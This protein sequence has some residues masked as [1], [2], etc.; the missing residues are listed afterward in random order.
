MTKKFSVLQRAA[1]LLAALCLL[2]GLALP[3]CAE[4]T[5]DALSAQN[6]ETMQQGNDPTAE[7]LPGE[8][9]DEDKTAPD[10]AAATTPTPT[11]T[12]TPAATTTPTPTATPAATPTPAPTATL[13]ATPTPTPTAAPTA[14]PTT[15]P[16][17]TPTAKPTP[18]VTPIPDDEEN[19]ESKEKFV[20]FAAVNAVAE[21][22]TANPKG[23][24]TIYFVPPTNWT[25]AG[26]VEIY[27]R[28]LR[29]A[30]NN[31]EYKAAMTKSGEITKIG[32]R[33]IYEIELSYADS[34][35]SCPH[36]GY[37]WVQFQVGDNDNPSKRIRIRT[38]DQDSNSWLFVGEMGGKCF[39]GDKYFEGDKD[40]ESIVITDAAAVSK[41][42]AYD[43]IVKKH[44]RYG[45]QEIY[46]QNK[47]GNELTN[48]TVTFYEKVNGEYK[49]VGKEQTISSV[50]AGGVSDAITIPGEPCAYVSFTD[51][52]GF[53]G[54]QYYNFYKDDVASNEVGTFQ[55]NAKTNDC[56]IYNGQSDVQWGAPNATR[57]YFDATFSDMSY[58]G[59]S[60][61]KTAD[62]MPGNDGKLYYILT[63]EGKTKQ[64]GEMTRLED[65]S[66]SR[67][68]WYVNAPEGYTKV[69]FSDTATLPTSNDING[70]ATATLTWGDLKEPCFYAD[71]GDDITYGG[72]YR[73]GY[74]GEKSAIRDVEKGKKVKGKDAEIVKLGTGTFTPQNNVKYI[75]STLYDYYSDYELNG[76]TRANYSTEEV[77]T[78]RSYVEFEQFDRA[79]SDYYKDYEA[80]TTTGEKVQYPLYTGHFQPD[81]MDKDW[82][83]K[84]AANL[85]LYGWGYEN[86]KKDSLYGRFMAVNNANVDV[87]VNTNNNYTVN[88]HTTFQGL[89]S[90]TR[91][92]NHN[93]TLY[94][95]DLPEPHF[96]EA[97]LT[98]ENSAKAVLGKVYKDVAFPFKQAPIFAESGDR[99]D[100]ENAA[101]Y[102][103][104]D[105]SETPLYLKQDT[106]KGG[107][108]YLDSKMEGDEEKRSRNL[109]TINNPTGG[110]GFFPFNQYAGNHVNQ[111]NYGYGA[112]LQFDFTLTE[113]G[114]VVV[115]KD[116]KG[117][118]KVPI[119]FFFSG[120][121]D[122]WVFI[123]DQ[124]VL[125][126]GGAHAKAQGLLEFGKDA[127]GDNTVTSYV[128]NI[129]ASNN[130]NYTQLDRSKNVTFNGT[131]YQFNWKSNENK[132]MTLP[133]N[134]KHTLTMYYMERGMWESNMA[135]AFNFPD[136]NELQVEKQVD[137]DGVRE[138]LQPYFTNSTRQFT[139][140]IKN[141]A[142]HYAALNPTATTDAGGSSGIGFTTK[143]YTIPDYDS[144]NKGKLVDA[145]GAQYTTSKDE[146]IHTVEDNGTFDLQNG[147]I[148]TF[149]DQF[150]RGSYISLQEDLQEDA[151]KKLYAPTWEIHENG[152]LVMQS[153]GGTT[154]ELPDGTPQKIMQG[155]G[156]T[157]DDGRKE[158][159]QEGEEDGRKIQNTGYTVTQKPKENSIVFR[160][161]RDPDGT[162]Q[163]TKLKVKFIN[164]VKTGSLSIT[165]QVPQ[166]EYEKLKGETYTFTVEYS[167]IGGMQ[168]EGGKKVTE[169]VQVKVGDPPFTL[170]GIPIGTTV[171]V[172][173]G[174][175]P[176][177][178][179]KSI[180]VNGS[181]Q[182]ADGKASGT[183][184]ADTTD[185]NDSGKTIPG[186]RVVFTNTARKPITIDVKKTWQNAK[187][188]LPESI[189]IELQRRHAGSADDAPWTD[190]K[191]TEVALTKDETGKWTHTF[192]G[193][194]AYDISD[195]KNTYYEYRVVEWDAEKGQ[196][197]ASGTLTLGNYN[198]KVDSETKTIKD[199]VDSVSLTLTNTQVPPVYELAITKQGLDE[200]GNK[201]KLLNGV[202]FKLEKLNGKDVDTTFNGNKGSMPGTT[203]GDGNDAGKCRFTNLSEGSYR[204]TELKTV[205]GY[206]LLAAPIEFTLQKGECLINGTKQENMV[207]GKPASGYTVSLTINNRKGFTLPHTGADAPSLWLL[208]GLPLLVAGLLVLVFRY[209]RKGGKRS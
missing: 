166:D 119:R 90:N 177:R 128:S 37:V 82:F 83:S 202:E 103:Y 66:E 209:N 161:Y 150:R 51:E 28:G 77:Q 121:D 22:G 176:N 188:E 144:V 142:T 148:V 46:F 138:K 203:T 72:G 140:G 21:G 33:P 165:K 48:I 113:D 25:K 123:D 170:K 99:N 52:N 93:P 175:T 196:Y 149:A 171:T 64:T 152:K 75:D 137:A 132:Q 85:D 159:Y 182:L 15:T 201:P 31:G 45:G 74:W 204:L 194:D 184:V 81:K 6:V 19:G 130:N 147:E 155:D 97:F 133:K 65:R 91:D 189:R 145:A 141:W 1:A 154:V 88:S 186:V 36:G 70:R 122:V 32:E 18:T 44:V 126:V 76:K 92:G 60:E 185:A 29:G 115:G 205:D 101:Q 79:L 12:A 118:K 120:D 105:S 135:V 167:N 47:T 80:S 197:T 67:H 20:T 199:N 116:E 124:L 127:S 179:I 43:D 87:N 100:P 172:T 181:E 146:K 180:T 40:K 191:G 3:V 108:Y 198:Y 195:N 206:N 125:D 174:S 143:Q 94:G 2:A 61:S 5:D 41:L 35:P 178:Y 164:K 104:Y 34:S 151:D 62:G 10:G 9:T 84:I 78:H 56:F 95:T 117:E 136:H 153:N 98:G 139:V 111:Y 192:H 110:Y 173:E 131:G 114:Q 68:L 71:T 4:G 183:I 24:Y 38:T 53:I 200:N 134:T 187:G 106:S 7:T 109:N 156:T 42:A 17:A 129:K 27:F 26:D 89:V 59:D 58:S 54:K 96:N 158:K 163:F 107:G 190:V 160:S 39:E 73:D 207:T 112:K 16:T 30:N 50:P 13:T 102:W 208:I 169:T 14:T 157:P 193:M 23:N 63:G 86:D 57:I 11:P 8:Q 168:L 69:Q 162:D 49:V 55:Y